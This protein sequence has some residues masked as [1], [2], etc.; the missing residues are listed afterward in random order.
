M[1]FPSWTI[2]SSITTYERVC[3]R[4]QQP[5]A[6]DFSR[7]YFTY[8]QKLGKALMLPVAALPIAGILMG[9]GY[10][11]AHGTMGVTGADT[12]GAAYTVGLVLVKA[13][14]V[15]IDNFVMMLIVLHAVL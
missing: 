6:H 5:E 8:L 10:L 15:L 12:S 3:R 2:R 1:G 13:G 14:G 7:V 4:P 9:L 11:L